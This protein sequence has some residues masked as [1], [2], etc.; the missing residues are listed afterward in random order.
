MRRYI[1]LAICL[2]L[3]VMAFAGTATWTLPTEYTDATPIATADIARITTTLYYGSSSSGPWTLITTTVAGATTA[4][5]PDPARG[6]T[7]WY[8]AEANLDGQTSAKGVAVSKTTPFQTPKAPSGF[9]I[10]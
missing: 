4:T 2:L 8:T 9:T 5:V 1:F 7:R 6:A 3:P 10:Q